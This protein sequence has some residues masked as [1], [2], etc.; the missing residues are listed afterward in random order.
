M[1]GTIGY[2]YPM[3]SERTERFKWPSISLAEWQGYRYRRPP[4]PED[5]DAS[6]QTIRSVPFN[7]P[8]STAEMHVIDKRKRNPLTAS[9]VGGI[10][11]PMSIALGGRAKKLLEEE[12]E[13]TPPTPT[14][15]A[16]RS[17]HPLLVSKNTA[18]FN[19]ILPEHPKQIT[20]PALESQILFVPIKSGGD[21]NYYIK[22]TSSRSSSSSPSNSRR[23]NRFVLEL[24]DPPAVPP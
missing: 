17:G 15:L 3:G 2:G 13:Y 1:T 5:D 6:M 21:M 22:S 9:T 20:T 23:P 4:P 11:L 19:A 12:D 24:K 18:G 14:R 16:P 7:P 10:K 8:P